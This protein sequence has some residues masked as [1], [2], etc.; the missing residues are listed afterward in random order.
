MEGNTG[1]RTNIHMNGTDKQLERQTDIQMDGVTCICIGW[2]LKQTE[3]KCRV[4]WYERIDRQTDRHTDEVGK[5][6]QTGV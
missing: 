3:Y 5:E 4:E 2:M 1:R 6:K